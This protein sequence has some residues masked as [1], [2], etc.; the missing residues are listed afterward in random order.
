VGEVAEDDAGRRATD[1]RE[2]GGLPSL[3][4]VPPPQRIYSLKLAEVTSYLIGCRS[5]ALTVN[6]TIDELNAFYKAAVSHNLRL[7]WWSIPGLLWTTVALRLNLSS[8]RQLEAAVLRDLAEVES[9]GVSD[10]A[11]WYPDPR[12]DRTVL[13]WDGTTWT[14]QASAPAAGSSGDAS[15]SNADGVYQS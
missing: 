11:G 14:Q 2:D 15:D 6:G 1:P 3:E 5:Q 13:Y 4:S 8:L 12:D 10:L 7:G 9:S